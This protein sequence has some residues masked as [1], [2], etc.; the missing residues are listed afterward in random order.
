MGKLRELLRGRKTYI[1]AIVATVVAVQAW[2]DGGGGMMDLVNAVWMQ[3][4]VLFLR[5]GIAAK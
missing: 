3:L 2:A 1:T 5:A 4:S